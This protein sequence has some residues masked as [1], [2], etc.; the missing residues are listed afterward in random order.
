MCSTGDGNGIDDDD[1]FQAGLPR[2]PNR[3]SSNSKILIA[4]GRECA[5]RGGED[6]TNISDT[7]LI[8]EIY[9]GRERRVGN[10]SN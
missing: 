5:K 2:G 8:S 4:V 6:E 3:A 10:M 7:N 9:G 1:N